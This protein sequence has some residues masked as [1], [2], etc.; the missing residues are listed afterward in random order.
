MAK[1]LTTSGTSYYIES[2]ILGAKKELY[3]VSPYLQISKTLSE[4]LKDAASNGV[5]IKIIYGKS[6]LL[7]DQLKLLESI[8]NLQIYFFDNLH[9]KCYFNEQTMVITSMNMYQFSEKNNR[10]MGIFIDKDADADLFGDAYRETKSIIQ[11][12]VIHKKTGAIIKKESS[13]NIIQKE[14]TKTQNP[15]GFCIRCNDKISYNIE[16]PYCKTC[17]YIWSEW[18]NYN[19]VEV[20]CHGCGKPEAT[21]FMKPEC[22]SCFKKNS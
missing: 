15:K 20:G 4:R 21:T 1:F 19:Y 7:A 12:A 6:N 10:E 5:F 2:I 8:Q 22:Y 18:E 16:R 11:S 14:K 3:L 9:A 17:F 13:V